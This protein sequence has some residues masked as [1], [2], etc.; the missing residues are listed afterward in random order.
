MERS[1]CLLCPFGCTLS[2]RQLPPDQVGSNRQVLAAHAP[3]AQGA[4]VL[5]E[6][7]LSKVTSAKLLVQPEEKHGLRAQLFCCFFFSSR[8]RLLSLLLWVCSCCVG[9]FFLKLRQ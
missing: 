5:L 9:V 4:F 6:G 1:P 2:A 7:C 3:F 8:E